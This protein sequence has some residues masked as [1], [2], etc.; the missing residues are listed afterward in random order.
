MKSSLFFAV[1]LSISASL[2]ATTVTT[3]LPEVNGPS[4]PSGPFPAS[5]LDAGTFT[6]AI[7]AGEH[8]ISAILSGTYGNSQVPNSAGLDLYADGLLIGQCL[9]NALC[10]TNPDAVTPFSYS[11]NSANFNL[12]ADGSLGMSVVQTSGNVVRL[13]AETLTI[14]TSASGVPEPGSFILLGAGLLLVTLVR[15]TYT[16]PHENS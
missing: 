6:F 2:H 15:F 1:L 14:Q 16:R 3:I 10:D 4:L 7:P 8:I 11:F 12:L 9:A 13:G 5:L